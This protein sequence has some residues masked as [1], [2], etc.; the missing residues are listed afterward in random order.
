MPVSTRRSSVSCP[1]V[2]IGDAGPAGDPGPRQS[3][4]VSVLWV[5]DAGRRPSAQ[6]GGGRPSWSRS[7]LV[8]T[9]SC[10][11]RASVSASHSVW[12]LRADQ[13]EQRCRGT[14]SV[15]PVR[16]SCRVRCFS[17][18]VL[19]APTTWV[20]RRTAM[21]S[22]AGNRPQHHPVTPTAGLALPDRPGPA[23]GRGR[24]HAPS[25]GGGGRS[26]SGRQDT[27]WPPGPRARGRCCPSG[28][29]RPPWPTPPFPLPAAHRSAGRSCFGHSCAWGAPL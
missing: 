24:E 15:L 10:S 16:V 20:P 9:N 23:T 12:G 27:A 11:S 6:P 8:R 4:G 18:P 28:H 22:L 3:A 13:D 2:E 29:P 17:R 7:R 1:T 14:V 25:E 26:W 19:W 21:A 5:C